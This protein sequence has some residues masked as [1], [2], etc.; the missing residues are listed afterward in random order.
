MTTDGRNDQIGEVERELS[1][2]LGRDEAELAQIQATLKQLHELRQRVGQ[3]Q[4][5]PGD[6]ALL[7]ALVEEMMGTM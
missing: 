6:W 5:E 4:L 7:D 1:S 3:G 2:E